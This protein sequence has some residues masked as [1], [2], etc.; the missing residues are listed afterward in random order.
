MLLGLLENS[1]RRPGFRTDNSVRD[2]IMIDLKLF[3]RILSYGA[4]PAVRLKAE[5]RLNF[6]DV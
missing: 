2:Q 1:E 4:K 6:C 3:D 5:L